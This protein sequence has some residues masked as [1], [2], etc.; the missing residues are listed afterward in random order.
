LRDKQ[1]NSPSN[2]RQALCPTRRTAC[3]RS[4]YA[5][6]QLQTVAKGQTLTVVPGDN[7]TA[8]ANRHRVSVA[9]LMRVNNLQSPILRPGQDIRIP[10]R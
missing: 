1:P 9:E 10:Q 5:A 7:L 6:P 8:I 3:L 2:L 4:P